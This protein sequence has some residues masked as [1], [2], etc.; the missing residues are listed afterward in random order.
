MKAGVP[1]VVEEGTP[2]DPEA[3]AEGLK[4]G[5]GLLDIVMLKKEVGVPP[6]APALGVA[7]GCGGDGV[8]EGLAFPEL[9]PPPPLEA[10]LLMDA[11]G[12]GLL[13]EDTE[14]LGVTEAVLA[15]EGE[16]AGEEVLLADPRELKLTTGEAETLGEA[17]TAEDADGLLLAKELAEEQRDARADLLKLEDIDVLGEVLGLALLCRETL[18]LGD[19]RALAESEAV[20]VRAA[21]AVKPV[22]VVR[23]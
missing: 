22:D 8:A 2:A 4:S 12:V 15:E 17:L 3:L 9:L 14:A 6:S 21:E 10:V 23:V 20:A 11:S 18:A 5:V 19:V 1:E 13:C 7:L 16:R